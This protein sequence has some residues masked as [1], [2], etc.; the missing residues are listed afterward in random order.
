MRND[1][2]KDADEDLTG[3]NLLRMH[4]LEVADDLVSG[5]LSSAKGAK[6]LRKLADADIKDIE[7]VDIEID[8]DTGKSPLVR[9]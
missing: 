8:F 2:E 7:E 9:S 5:K 3:R 1:I 6:Q 4:I